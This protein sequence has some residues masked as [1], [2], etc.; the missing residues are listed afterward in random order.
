MTRDNRYYATSTWRKKRQLKLKLH[1]NTCDICGASAVNKTEMHVHHLKYD[2]YGGDERMSDL[3]V[4]CVD[5][6]RD[7]HRRRENKQRQHLIGN[8]PR[9]K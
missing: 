2:R 3:Q 9:W 5:C 7:H 4:L 1:D 8:D 6:H